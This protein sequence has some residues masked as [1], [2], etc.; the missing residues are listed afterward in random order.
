VVFRAREDV[1]RFFT[2][3][4]IARVS[5]VAISVKEDEELPSIPSGRAFYASAIAPVASG[6]ESFDVLAA[7]I[8]EGHARGIEILAWVPQFHD[9][10]AIERDP[11]WEMATLDE[12]GAVVPY[13]GAGGERFA[14]PAHPGARAYERSIVREIA[15]RYA[16]D[17]I[18]LDWIRYDGWATG[19]EEA[20]ASGYRV[21]YGVD[22]AAIDFAADGA[23]RARWGEHRAEIVAS[24]VRE[25][26]ADLGPGVQ[27]GA[28]VLPSAW[29][30]L[31]QDAGRF[32]E[33]VDRI[34]P[35]A[36]FDDWG[37]VPSWVFE[38]VV[39]RLRERVGEG[40]AIV[41]TLDEDWTD[42]QNEEVL[43]GLRARTPFVR[44]VAWFAYGDW[45][46]A[47]VARLAPLRICA[48]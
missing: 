6:Y 31:S 10:T 2:A 38:E 27:L 47:L 9:A 4:E 36:Y 29:T 12:T 5:A 46:D 24:H 34:Y 8:E 30:E 44:S 45:S 41:P 18:V 20:T 48:P 13:V 40:P 25:V 37:L 22:P 7:A 16:V 28:F 19:L 35:M 15:E 39:P 26:R 32:A 33:A 42:A 23:E 17:G 11:S 1:T 14:S 21:R 43:A 3:A